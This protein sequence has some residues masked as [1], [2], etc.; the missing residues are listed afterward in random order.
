MP[1]GMPM[2]SPSPAPSPGSASP[3]SANGGQVKIWV[4]KTSNQL[5]VAAPRS[6]MEEIADLLEVLDTE[7]TQDVTIRVIPL[8]N[9]SAED[10][11]KEIGPLYQKMGAQSAKDRIEITANNRSNSLIVLSSESNFEAIQKLVTALDKEEAQ[12]KMLRAFTLVNADA[13]DVAEQLQEL[14]QDQGS[15]NRYPFYIFSSSMNRQQTQTSVVADRR[16]N[17]VLVQAPPA[18]MEQIEEL[19]RVLDAPISD[20]S[21]TPKIFRLQFISATDLEDVLNELFLK[22]QQEQRSYWSY[23]DYY[24]DQDTQG[25]GGKLYGKVRITSEP[26][27][28]SL[29]VTAN[30][31]ESL[32]AVEAVIRELDSPSQAGETTMRP[33]GIIAAPPERS[34][35][36]V[37]LLATEPGIISILL[38]LLLQLEGALRACLRLLDARVWLGLLGGVRAQGRGA[39]LG[40]K[41]Y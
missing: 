23:Y 25:E 4:D 11:V 9:V 18:E 10:L 7:E 6:R 37:I 1:P 30:S 39:S 14:Q 33:W 12:E 2:P 8:Q 40:K 24:G 3:A 22:K 27:S 38:R 20:N 17:A 21:L 19:I 31:P 35:P 5:I 16:R 26:Y 29:I 28:N 34:K 41:E 13:E 32:A 15:Q 36:A